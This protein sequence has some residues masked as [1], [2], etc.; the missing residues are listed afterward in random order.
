MLVHYYEKHFN[1]GWQVIIGKQASI[2]EKTNVIYF[3]VIQGQTE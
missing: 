3:K 1:A 2:K